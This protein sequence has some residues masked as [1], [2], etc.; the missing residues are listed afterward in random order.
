[1]DF[2]SLGFCEKKK[3]KPILPAALQNTTWQLTNNWLTSQS[4]KL[5]QLWNS[6]IKKL[7]ST[8]TNNYPSP[9]PKK[10]KKKSNLFK[11]LNCRCRLQC[12]R[13]RRSYIFSF[14]VKMDQMS[15]CH[16]YFKLRTLI[17]TQRYFINKLQHLK[18]QFSERL[19]L[20][21]QYSH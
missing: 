1:M 15:C 11:K 18:S 3:K 13:K 20:N 8:V 14:A 2:H 9:L 21:M 5:H 6:E 17:T 7:S 4:P 10:K 12:I 19:T 16:Y